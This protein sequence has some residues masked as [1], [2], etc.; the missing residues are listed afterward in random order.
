MS[1]AMYA[2][3]Y[4][5]PPQLLSSEFEKN[6]Q[7]KKTSR[8]K[9]QKNVH[10]DKVNDILLSIN[11]ETLSDFK[12]V[13]REEVDVEKIQKTEYKGV[14]NFHKN[15]IPS[16]I[17]VAKPN[18][19]EPRDVLIDK[20]N[21]IIGLLENQQDEKTN[22]TEDL[23]IYALLGCFIIFIIDKFVNVGKYVR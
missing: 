5:S 15:I 23:I 12:E 8:P 1:L 9:T 3:P 19:Q 18:H 10:S 6:N 11:E 13:E 17:E 21:Y 16:Y 20:V 22:V 14:T 2:C 4:D 7:I